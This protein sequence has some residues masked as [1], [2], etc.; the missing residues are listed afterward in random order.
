[1]SNK[2]TTA[3]L[4]S[5]RQYVLP[6]GVFHQQKPDRTSDTFHGWGELDSHVAT[7][8]VGRNCTILHHTERSFDVAPFSDTYIPMKDV[9]IVLAA[10]GFIS[11]T[12]Q[13]YILVFNEALYM[14]ELDHTLINTIQLLQVY[15]QV[16]DNPYYAT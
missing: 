1:M 14:T 12:S 2:T 16:Q 3:K 8:V 4:D 10:T 7:T 5:L 13:K 11:V 15:T 6:T 9:D